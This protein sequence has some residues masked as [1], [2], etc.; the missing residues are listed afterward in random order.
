MSNGKKSIY[1][2]LFTIGSYSYSYTVLQF[3]A[4]TVISRL[5]TP[6]EY[7][8]VALI[9]VFTGF[10]AFFK[11]AGISYV[12]IR[13]DY[14]I[15]FFRKAQWL[16]III[17]LV[18]LSIVMLLAYPISLFYDQP[19][20]F[21]PTC[22][23]SL[24]LFIEAAS[25]V[26]M[27]VLKKEL[28][29]RAVGQV[30]FIGYVSGSVIT[31]IL[32]YA[33]FSYWSLVI[34]QLFSVI[35][36]FFLLNRHVP[37][38][39]GE[40]SKISL[41]LAWRKTRH[42]LFNISGS[43]F[44]QYWSSNAD[45]LIIGKSFGAY[46]LGIYNRAYQLLTMQ[47][48]LISGLFNT[49]LL[50]SLKEDKAKSDSHLEM[51]YLSALN[52]MSL[53][54]LPVTLSLVLFAK[55]IIIFVWGN[56]WLDVAPIASYFGVL[57]IPFIL[58][59]T[60]GNVYVLYKKENL[61]FKLG[62]FSSIVSVTAIIIGSSYGL[63]EVALAVSLVYIALVLPITLYVSFYKS[64]HFNLKRLVYFWAIKII[65]SIVMLIGLYSDINYLTKF[66][67]VILTLDILIQGKAHIKKLIVK[68]T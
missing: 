54:V 51:S 2:N 24:V 28:K 21:L 31:I 7:G 55:P 17:G 60:F 16:S 15:R 23:I 66:C 67:L 38:Y 8:L 46:S 4:S 19:L 18:L 33:G 20:L 52:L 9:T 35:V 59:R 30:L 25:I 12:V 57:S 65:L 5:L 40:V 11:D 43:R 50:P 58:S 49:I 10:I 44:I 45:N 36:I 42:T 22:L 29:F 63:E 6:E 13:E 53:L 68:I 3:L 47:M 14:D 62:V 41:Y 37:L 39:L 27:A 34:G 64:F 26:P 61:L 1:S 48:N 32:A 56:D